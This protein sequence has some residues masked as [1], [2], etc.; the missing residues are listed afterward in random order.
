MRISFIVIIICLILNGCSDVYSAK[1]TDV[2][3]ASEAGA[4]IRGWLP[5]WLPSNAVNIY[6]IHNLDTNVQAFSYQLPEIQKWPSDCE[7][8]KSTPNPRL[9]AKSFPENLHEFS[10]LK[11]CDD[12][13]G[14]SSDAG[15]YYFWNNRNYK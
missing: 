7:F 5:D 3:E 11:K 9:K 6:E 2:D 14:A 12:F 8:V 15:I 10:D 13:W 4:F 1:F